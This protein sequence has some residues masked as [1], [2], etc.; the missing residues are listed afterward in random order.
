MAEVLK[1]QKTRFQC[2]TCPK[3]WATKATAERHARECHRDP[4]S[5]ACT[6][7]AHDIREYGENYGPYICSID[8]KAPGVRCVRRCPYWTLKPSLALLEVRRAVGMDPEGVPA[9]S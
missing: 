2:S 1:I 7:C 9:C 8:E 4:A 3:N 5:R 6:T